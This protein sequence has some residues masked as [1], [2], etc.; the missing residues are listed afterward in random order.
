MQIQRALASMTLIT[1]LAFSGGSALAESEEG[2][3]DDAII[4]AEEAVEAVAR[5]KE[6]DGGGTPCQD[7]S[8]PKIRCKRPVVE[9]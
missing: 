8:S 5:D 3:M 4:E 9:M 7:S 1:A 2:M 6:M